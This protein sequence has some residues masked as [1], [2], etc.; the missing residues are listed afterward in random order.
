VGVHLKPRYASADRMGKLI[1][2]SVQNTLKENQKP[3]DDLL[4][5]CGD[6]E[7]LVIEWASPDKHITQFFGGKYDSIEKL[8]KI[9]KR[10]IELAFREQ[11]S[12]LIFFDLWRELGEAIRELMCSDYDSVARSLRWMIEAC[13]LWADM[14]LDDVT[15][16]GFFESYNSHREKLTDEEFKRLLSEIGTV[17]EARL[18]E[19]L[20]FKEKFRNI[21]MG[22]LLKNLQNLKKPSKNMEIHEIREKIFSLYRDFSRYSHITLDTA[23]EIKMEP[24][25]LHFDFAFFQ[26]YGY[27]KERFKTEIERIYGT[28][29]LTF[30]I[31]VLVVANFYGYKTPGRLFESCK[32]RMTYHGK[33]KGKEIKDRI[34]QSKNH[35]PFMYNIIAGS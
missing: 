23:K 27:D 34:L 26:G 9:Q 12:M 29:D 10:C 4:D 25:E 11:T 19:R 8:P 13:V 20:V 14:Q 1:N 7:Y 17:N 24:G 35:F 18:V 22:D 16:Q 15:A 31:I 2:L 28:L 30:S 33:E 21:R 6:L 5:F 32:E 3:L